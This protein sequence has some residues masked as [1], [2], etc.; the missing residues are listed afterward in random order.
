MGEKRWWNL[1]VF[2]GEEDGEGCSNESHSNGTSNK[3][4]GAIRWNISNCSNHNGRRSIPV[5]LN[6]GARYPTWASKWDLSSV[7]GNTNTRRE[8]RCILGNHGLK[9][10]R[11][12]CHVCWH[13][14][15]D[16][17]SEIL[18]GLSV[19]VFLVLDVNMT[20]SIGFILCMKSW[21]WFEKYLDKATSALL[22]IFQGMWIRQGAQ[23]RFLAGEGC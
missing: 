6:P 22:E 17:R 3:V 16:V 13:E 5:P 14:I 11:H 19:F 4:S 10:S 23:P 20:H 18:E 9:H 2:A 21:R 15:L 12:G 1:R 8:I 7:V